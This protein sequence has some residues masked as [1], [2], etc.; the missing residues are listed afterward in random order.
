MSKYTKAQAIH[1]KRAKHCSN[2]ALAAYI[3]YLMKKTERGS[4]PLL[5]GLIT[6]CYT[7]EMVARREKDHPMYNGW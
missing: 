3:N 4:D 1:R 2:D 6:A 5:T 7:D